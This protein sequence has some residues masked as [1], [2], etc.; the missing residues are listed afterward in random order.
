MNSVTAKRGDTVTLTVNLSQGVTVGSGGIALTYDTA[1]LELVKG[2]WNVLGTMLSTFNTSN[3]KGAFAY[4][5]GTAISGKV[6]TATFKVKDSAAFGTST[7]KMEL[8]LKDGSNADITVTNNSG[9]VTV[10]CNH[11]YSAWSSV[12]ANNHTRT[13]SA[14]NNKETV[15]H[16]FDNAC[17]TKCDDCG[18]TRTTTHSYKTTWSSNSSKHWHECSHCKAKTDEVAHTPG[19][20]ATET[21]PQ[22]CTVCGY[23][24]QKALGH[25]HKPTGD[26]QMD[27]NK[28]WK[29]CSTCDKNA[30]EAAHRYDNTCDTD[31]NDCGYKR[32]VTH[33]YA[34]EWTSDKS[35]HW[36]AC[37]ICG[38]KDE[39][40]A[41]TS[42]AEATETTP[43]LCTVCN[44]E[45][46]PPKAHEHKYEGDWQSDADNHW[47]N[48]A[49]GESSEKATHKWDNG[50]VVTQPTTDQAGK[51]TYTC[52]ECGAT[53]N[54]ELELVEKAPDITP[55]TT[56]DNDPAIPDNGSNEAPEGGFSV[57][58]MLIGIV[59]GAVIGCAIGVGVMLAVSKKKR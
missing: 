38:G 24:I 17:D 59:I 3:N 22:T 12:D 45:I 55:D 21:T 33:T 58:S 41:H 44:F 25:T 48:C 50:K 2:E 28:H 26:W 49:C 14:C 20:A 13:C 37:T 27:A 54:V 39:L 5:A 11:K 8:Q 40:I 15:K 36:H 29:D 46:A 34:T 18:F 57:G 31:C 52:T 10:N 56:P 1:V 43:Q 30:E 51:K 47:K 16:G 4:T 19:A 23:V 6:F 53:K 9:K 35:G 32:T 7:V 42:G